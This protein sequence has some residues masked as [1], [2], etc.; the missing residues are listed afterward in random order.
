MAKGA[1]EVMSR[2]LAAELWAR[3]IR[4]NTLAPGAIETDFSGGYVRDNSEVNNA[5]ASQ[6]ALG[7]VGQPEDIGGVMAALLSNDSYWINGQ[8]IEASG[9]MKL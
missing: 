5:I 2:Y 8:R 6:T 9:G 3:K 1:I 4:V 7:R